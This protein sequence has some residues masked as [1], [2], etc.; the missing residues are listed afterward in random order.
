MT[1]NKHVVG[2]IEIAAVIAVKSLNCELYYP[3]YN[4]TRKRERA[5]DKIGKKI[6]RLAC[7]CVPYYIFIRSSR[8]SFSCAT[9]TVFLIFSFSEQRKFDVYKLFI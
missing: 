7:I 5:V 6:N 4:K 3:Y 8:V 2:V 1:G 9:K